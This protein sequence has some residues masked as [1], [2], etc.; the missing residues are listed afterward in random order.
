VSAPIDWQSGF[1][2]ASVL[3]GEPLDVALA[4]LAG[5]ETAGARELAR[6]LSGSDRVARARVVA[7]VTATLV[8]SLASLDAPGAA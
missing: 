2:A 6:E 1:L 3:L 4:A 5:R 8:A 7:R